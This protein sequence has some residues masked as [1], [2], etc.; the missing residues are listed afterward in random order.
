MQGIAN[1]SLPEGRFKHYLVQDYL[2]L[3]WLFTASFIG[4]LLQFLMNLQVHF[5]RSN[6][7]ASYKGKSMESIAAVSPLPVNDLNMAC[8]NLMRYSL[9]GLYCTLSARWHCI[10]TTVPLLDCL[11]KIWRAFLRRLVHIHSL[12]RCPDFRLSL[13]TCARQHARDTVD[14]SST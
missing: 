11:S 13:T 5:A 14:I 9:P 7:L 8:W 10:W 6:A 3:V 12:S 2:Y 4:P 1:G